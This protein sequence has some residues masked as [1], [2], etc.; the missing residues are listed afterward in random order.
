MRRLIPFLLL[1]SCAA[2]FAQPPAENRPKVRAITAFVR[3]DREHYRE[4]VA[5]ALQFLHA[6]RS[7]YQAAGFEV[8]TIRITTQ[9]FPE[10]VRGLP[11]D[12]AAA[13]LHGFDQLAQKENFDA[14]IGPAM[15]ND[16]DPPQNAALL[17]R[18][19]A[20][21]KVLNGSLIVAGADGIHWGSVKAAARV[22]KYLEEHSPDSQATFNFAA[23]A[24]L[25]PYA[26]FYPG[27]YHNGP[28]KH[29][30]VGLQSANLV[31]QAFSEAGPAD[32]RLTAL[33]QRW[34][35]QAEAIALQLAQQ[36]GWT[37]E[38]IDP[39]PAPLGDASIGEAIE[40]FTG[41]PFGAGGTLTAASV[42]TR[43]V[44]AVQV[45]H[46]GYSGLMLPVM[47]DARLA[48]RW[49]EGTYNIDSL[50]AYS[51]VCATGLDTVPLPGD[52][53]EEQLA[54][55]IGDMAALAVKWNKPLATRLQPVAGRKAGE[56][57]AFNDPYLTN[58]LIRPLPGS[59]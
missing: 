7:A 1:L 56:R 37:F 20:E 23:T 55:I 5:Q 39:T 24:M 52:V 26:P 35:S 36:T 2:V 6:A 19:L 25:A 30:S 45:K 40:K 28:G 44:R 54:D 42:I 9:P 33:L 59:R 27:S 41:H 15:Q 21:S 34:C 4:E 16:S 29:F 18:V 53:T 22:T 11:E 14:N 48:Q 8:Q 32:V 12:E 10:I 3:L 17:A 31:L 51:A 46:V 58:T 49:S 57:T 47:E 43:S 13:F 50:L 38:G